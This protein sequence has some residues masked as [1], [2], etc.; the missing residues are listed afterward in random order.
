MRPKPNGKNGPRSAR[1]M[2]A[3]QLELER[4]QKEL[5]R[6]EELLKA[7]LKGLPAEIKEK[8]DKRRE[9]M[10][11]QVTTAARGEYLARKQHLPG[12]GDAEVAPRRRLRAQQR[13]G[14]IKFL[15]LCLIFVTLFLLLL[16]VMP[17]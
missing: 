4:K 16:R 11:M 1:R 17:A 10:R 7:R 13:E 12:A 15:I 14:K 9:L 8:E 3:E 2:T 6:K 5:R